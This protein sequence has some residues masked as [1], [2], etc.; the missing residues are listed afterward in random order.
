MVSCG[1]SVSWMN[2]PRDFQKAPP[3]ATIGRA[4]ILSVCIRVAVSKTSSSVPNPP[5]K[6]TKAFEYLT[7]ITFLTKK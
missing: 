6:T 5:G 2:F 1:M 7:S 4:S 3:M